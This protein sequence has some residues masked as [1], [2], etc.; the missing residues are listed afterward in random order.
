M[1][2]SVAVCAKS[3]CAVAMSASSS[4]SRARRLNSSEG[5]SSPTTVTRS[6]RV[7]MRRVSASPEAMPAPSAT[8]R[9]SR[10]LFGSVRKVV[11]ASRLSG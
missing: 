1:V 3:S 7:P 8:V 4:E 10:T 11:S 9:E 2:L 5:S 6:A